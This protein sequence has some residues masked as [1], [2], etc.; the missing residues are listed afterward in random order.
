MWVLNWSIKYSYSYRYS[1]YGR[2]HLPCN[3]LPTTAPNK[4]LFIWRDLSSYV[5]LRGW[6][7][8]CTGHSSY[9]KRLIPRPKGELCIRFIAAKP[10]DI[11][12][13]CPVF[14]SDVASRAVPSLEGA[15]I[16]VLCK[17]CCVYFNSREY[18][19]P[20]RGPL[21]PVYIWEHMVQLA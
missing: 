3:R 16:I 11:K 8:S 1:R 2:I 20:A 17:T 12:K 14:L 18:K 19:T 6:H 9:F 15:N 13:L 10:K 21:S 7:S 4:Q 5:H